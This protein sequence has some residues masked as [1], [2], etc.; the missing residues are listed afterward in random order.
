[1]GEDTYLGFAEGNNLAFK[2]TKEGQ[3]C[4]HFYLLVMGAESVPDHSVR[5]EGGPTRL[6]AL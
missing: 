6:A 5:T 1:M 4:L 3:L 2:V